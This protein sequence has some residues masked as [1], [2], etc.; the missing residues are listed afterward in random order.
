M[1][2]SMSAA[3]WRRNHNTNMNF[4]FFFQKVSMVNHHAIISLVITIA[5]QV[6]R[7][8]HVKSHVQKIHMVRTARNSVTVKRMPSVITSLVSSI[9]SYSY[10]ILSHLSSV[11]HFA[12]LCLPLFLSGECHCLPGWIG[13]KC[14]SVCANGF[15]GLNCNQTCK[16]QNGGHC[17]KHDGFC[18]CQPGWTGPKC[19]E[20]K[21]HFS[22]C[23]QISPSLFCYFSVHLLIP[24]CPDGLF[25]I[26]CINVCECG[27]DDKYDCH[28]TRGCVCRKGL[29]GEVL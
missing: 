23:S 15:F 16:C 13:E 20:G 12:H 19:I 5:S 17:R 7:G 6:F 27:N 1:S 29:S 22:T 26:N 21:Y 8:C 14:G 4:F 10:W 25:G 3:Y 24:A 11:L 28:P 18:D 2:M 9:L